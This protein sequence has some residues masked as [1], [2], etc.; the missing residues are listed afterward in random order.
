MLERPGPTRPAAMVLGPKTII[1]KPKCELGL[2]AQIGPEFGPGAMGAYL[3]NK[4][5]RLGASVALK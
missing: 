4:G 3:R 2:C 5:G 1:C